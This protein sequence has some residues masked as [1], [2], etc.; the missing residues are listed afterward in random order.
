MIHWH[1]IVLLYILIRL[2]SGRSGYC[3]TLS[4]LGL[5]LCCVYTGE[6]GEALIGF[7]MDTTAV[8]R[9]RITCIVEW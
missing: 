7:T 9:E 8:A 1:T 2:Q 4:A 3:G 6:E 5:L